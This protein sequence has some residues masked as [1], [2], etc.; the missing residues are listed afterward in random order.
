MTVCQGGGK[1]EELVLEQ[2][3]GVSAADQWRNGETTEASV[4]AQLGPNAGCSTLRSPDGAGLPRNILW[5][6]LELLVRSARAKLHAW[7]DRRFLF[8]TV[9]CHNYHNVNSRK[10][11]RPKVRE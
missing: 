10:A 6:S 7:L 1:A 9:V 11:T 5:E 2:D 4:Y 8:G 3:V